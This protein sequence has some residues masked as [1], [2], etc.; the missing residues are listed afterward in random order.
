[1][2]HVEK[3]GHQYYGTEMMIYEAVDSCKTCDGASCHRCRDKY[4][5]EDWEKDKQLYSGFDKA[6]AERI[7]GNSINI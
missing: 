1:M 4:V 7:Y 6:E 3:T 2:A 5:V